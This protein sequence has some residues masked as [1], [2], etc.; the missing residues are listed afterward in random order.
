[1]NQALGRY[2]NQWQLSDP[3]PLAETFTSDLFKVQAFGQTAVLKILSEA[4][5]ADERAAADVLNWYDGHG[6]IRLYGMIPA[7]CF[8]NI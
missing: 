7:R 8:S 3:E 4:G 1:M 2:L 5:A 6:A